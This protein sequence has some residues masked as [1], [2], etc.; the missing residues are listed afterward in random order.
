[1]SQKVGEKLPAPMRFEFGVEAAAGQPGRAVV[2]GS[3]DADGSVRFAVLAAEEITVADDEHLRFALASG[4]ATSA[5]LIQRKH[6]SLWYVL[7]AAGYTIKGRVSGG[8]APSGDGRSVFDLE[9]ESVWRDFRPD[10]PMTGGAT[11]RR[12]ESG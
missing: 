11:Y 6:A 8:P 5:N 10:A 9:I 12:I 1:M 4:S 2:L 3:V 7:D